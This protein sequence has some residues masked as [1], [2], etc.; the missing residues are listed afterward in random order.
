M[1]GVQITPLLENGIRAAAVALIFLL[2]GCGA[3]APEELPD[4][5]PQAARTPARLKSSS[6]PASLRGEEGLPG[7]Y[8]Y[9]APESGCFNTVRPCSAGVLPHAP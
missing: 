3:G 5:A 2:G 8:T 1:R 6:P 7:T 9:T 4:T